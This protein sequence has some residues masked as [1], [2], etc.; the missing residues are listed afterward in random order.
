M[1]GGSGW[2][3]RSEADGEWKEVEENEPGRLEWMLCVREKLCFL[4]KEDNAK[5]YVLESYL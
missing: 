4:R 5:N 3:D 1:K 2:S